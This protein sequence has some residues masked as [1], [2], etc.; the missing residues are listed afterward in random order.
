MTEAA[1]RKWAGTQT[2]AIPAKAFE[3]FMTSTVINNLAII[4][5]C[6]SCGQTTTILPTSITNTISEVVPDHPAPEFMPYVDEVGGWQKMVSVP[7]YAGAGDET[8]TKAV[9]QHCGEEFGLEY[10]ITE[11]S[12]ENMK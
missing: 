12:K 6:D 3:N 4:F 5:D 7:K 1:F 11:W 2:V 10:P 9:C 8:P